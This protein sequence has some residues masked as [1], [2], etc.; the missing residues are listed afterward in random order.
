M[1]IIIYLVTC[2]SLIRHL[3][4][5]NLVACSAVLRIVRRPTFVRRCGGGEELIC[6]RF[7][8]V[9]FSWCPLDHDELIPNHRS[10]HCSLRTLLLL[11]SVP[12]FWVVCSDSFVTFRLNYFNCYCTLWLV[13]QRQS[14]N[15]IH[16]LNSISW[17]IL[18]VRIKSSRKRF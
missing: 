1:R 3:W 9:V 16:R 7:M 2:S 10:Y 6:G 17:R 5:H 15:T 18:L 13:R 14:R 8:C 4:T 11:P 12:V